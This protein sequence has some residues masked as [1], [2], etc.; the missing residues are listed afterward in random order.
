[1]TTR[2]RRLRLRLVL[3]AAVGL[4]AVAVALTLRSTEVLLP[5]ELNTI[6][7]RFSIRGE[8]SAPKDIAIVAIDDRSLEE[9]DAGQGGT[10]PRTVHARTLDRL[11]RDGARLILY[12]A[13][14]VGR[15]DARQ[16]RALLRA[17]S[18]ARPVVLATQLAEEGPLQVPVEADPRRLGASVGSIELTSDEDGVVRQMPY[19]D[20]PPQ[21]FSVVGAERA[22]GRPV[23]RA[24]FPDGYA[25]IDYRG[26]PDT[27]SHHSISRVAGGR[28]A[29]GTF[30]DKIVLVGA[31]APV[32]KDVFSTPTSA[33]PMPGVE[34]HA[35]ALASIL[36]DFPLSD[37]SSGVELVLT[38][39]LAL[40]APLLAARLSGV[41][42]LG[43]ALAGGL[44]FVVGAQLAFGEGSI[45]PLTYPLAGLAT[46]TAGAV[47]VDLLLETR[48][49][50][51]L[52]RNLSRFLPAHVLAEALERTDDDLR[53]GGELL[54]ATVLFCDLRGFAHFSERHSAATVI[55]TLNR[56]LTEMT[57]AV[58][59]H[60]GTVVSY[61]G[62]GLMAVFG[63]PIEQ[64]DHARRAVAAAREILDER[65]PVFNA[66]IRE[67]ELGEDFAI[68]VGICTGPVMSGNVGSARRVEYTAVGDTTNV[69]AR[70]QEKNKE[71]GTQVLMTE[72]TR[73]RLDTPDFE[74]E[75]VGEHTIL[76][77]TGHVRLWSIAGAH[78]AEAARDAGAATHAHVD[79]TT[80][81]SDS[82]HK[83]PGR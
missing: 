71:L 23:E 77:R 59:N 63:A 57:S 68:G 58:F 42:V 41:V 10:L 14:F 46:G 55:Q 66:W 2:R 17:I 19:F 73:L 67:R 81:P 25:W 16:D 60:D 33:D 8:R 12:D 28:V 35:N 44:A 34:I 80:G 51:R 4:L 75:D 18:R 48:E 70:L 53:L 9:L 74:L 61:M 45:V 37:A 5:V 30:R 49:R 39:I 32:L 22:T 7:A 83:P 43:C 76:G 64:P 47:G 52:R 36:A 11:R 38:L 3:L 20:E 78:S 79:G 50:M 31:T 6:D 69:A 24:E 15:S 82:P 1:M 26:P 29:P 56:Y 54:D 27:I 62:D 40:L 65:L 13:L 21:S 72:S